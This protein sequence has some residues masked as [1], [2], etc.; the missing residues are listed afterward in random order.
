MKCA[1]LMKL[2]NVRV[3][4]TPVVEYFPLH[5]LGHLPY[6]KYFVFN[7]LML[8]AVYNDAGG[9][10]PQTNSAPLQMA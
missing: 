7:Q 4:E 5:I 2:D 9:I 1:C 10:S 8:V 3:D 6:L